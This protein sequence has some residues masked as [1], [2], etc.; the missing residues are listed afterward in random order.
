MI[1]HWSL[2]DSK[3]LPDTSI[4][5]D[6]IHALTSMV[7]I[8]PISKP[9]GTVPRVPITTDIPITLMCH[10]FLN[11]LARSKYSSLFL[12]SLIFPL[13]SADTAKSTTVQVLFLYFFIITRL[14]LL[15]GIRWY[16]CISKSRRILCLILLDR[17][18]FVHIRFGR[19]VKFQFLAQLPVDL[20]SHPVVSSLFVLVCCIHLYD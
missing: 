7:L 4:L 6:L 9:L 1:F 12:L 11:F 2:N 14:G 5:T 8:S 13:W 19:M 10:S 18:W 20:L 15:T 3:F 17:I 16:V